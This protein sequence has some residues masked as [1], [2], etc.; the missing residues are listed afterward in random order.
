VTSEPTPSRR[1]RIGRRVQLVSATG[2][3]VVPWSR[4]NPRVR[5]RAVLPSLFTLGNMI[6]G[7]SS[8]LLSFQ[9]HYRAAAVLVAVSIV[10]DIADGAVARAVGA[11]TPFGLQFDSLADLISFGIA[12]AVLVYTWAL[13]AYPVWAWAG[14]MFWLACAAYRLARFNVTIDPLADKRYF[15]GLASPGAAGV[16]IATVLAIGE[17]LYDWAPL[18]PVA[19]GVLPAA[20]MASSFRF[21]SFRDLL[22]PRHLRI[23]VPLGIVLILGLIIVPGATALIVAYGYVL[24]CP[25]GWVTAPVRRRWFGPDAVAPPR[26]RLPSVIMPPEADPDD[27]SDLDPHDLDPHDLDP[28]DLDPHDLD[29]HDLDPG[30]LDHGENGDGV[31]AP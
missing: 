4:I 21:R 10:L 20:L 13:P 27:L 15:V 8:V 3:R 5:A 22:S 9:T 30:A 26:R 17:P 31:R 25:L 11:I 29:P 7:F 1:E 6:C 23:S 18:L 28:H 19:A 24:T 14:A 2:A 16:V 12:P